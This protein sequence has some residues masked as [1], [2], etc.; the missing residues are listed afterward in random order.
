MTGVTPDPPLETISQ[1]SFAN[2]SFGAGGV[3]WLTCI[4][5]AVCCKGFGFLSGWTFQCEENLKDS[6]RCCLEL[7]KW[8]HIWHHYPQANT[9]QPFFTWAWWQNIDEYWNRQFWNDGEPNCSHTVRAILRLRMF[10]DIE[11]FDDFASSNSDSGCVCQSYLVP[12][13]FADELPK[14]FFKIMEAETWELLMLWTRKVWRLD[15][16]D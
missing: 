11:Y 7:W 13:D 8:Q 4:L 14:G 6:S 5:L 12:S 10:L 3:G 1:L 16:S 2:A 15:L 9:D